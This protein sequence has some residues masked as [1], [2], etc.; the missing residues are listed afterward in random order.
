MYVWDT[1]SWAVENDKED[2]QEESEVEN[3]RNAR[4][5]QDCSCVSPASAGQGSVG[6]GLLVF[7]PCGLILPSPGGQLEVSDLC[8]AL[9][10]SSISW[11]GRLWHNSD[12][13]LQAA[14]GEPPLDF[15]NAYQG[16]QSA[17]VVFESNTETW[18]YAGAFEPLEGCMTFSGW[19]DPSL[20]FFTIQFCFSFMLLTKMSNS[21]HR[22]VSA[23]PLGGAL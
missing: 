1:G 5:W 11:C 16:L 22:I 4:N 23:V 15:R 7:L 2:C 13:P 10:V 8:P 18:K 21:G 9:E 19:S 12:C 3:G 20:L 14:P 6:W 17:L